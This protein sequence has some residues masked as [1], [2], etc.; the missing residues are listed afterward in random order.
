MDR[1]EWPTFSDIPRIPGLSTMETVM[2]FVAAFILITVTIFVLH[3][4]HKSRKAKREEAASMAWDKEQKMKKDLADK[5]R[6]RLGEGADEPVDTTPL[7]SGIKTLETEEISENAATYAKRLGM[8]A[9]KKEEEEEQ[10]ALV[11]NGYLQKSNTAPIRP[12]YS[13]TPDARAQ[14]KRDLASEEEE[15]AAKYS[16]PQR[17]KA[18]ALKRPTAAKVDSAAPVEEETTSAFGAIV[19]PTVG[20]E[21]ANAEV[22]RPA[23]VSDVQPMVAKTGLEASNA[24]AVKPVNGFKGSDTDKAKGPIKRPKSASV[25]KAQVAAEDA[26]KQAEK[27][28]EAMEKHQN[29]TAHDES[30]KTET[31]SPAP[32]PAEEEPVTAE[33]PVEQPAEPVAEI[34]AEPAIEEPAGSEPVQEETAS[35][36]KPAQTTSAQHKSNKKK[37]KKSG[38]KK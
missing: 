32:A 15:L 3:L 31:A 8:S 7:D 37:K 18:T 34:P 26:I 17:V 27:K 33:T 16:E 9:K 6:E 2:V 36:Q 5:R 12:V 4:D 38:K 20:S 13:N 22:E 25:N 28:A 10:Q 23:T 24:A 1:F 30:S 11:I 29:R 35:V 14:Q 19:R 21:V